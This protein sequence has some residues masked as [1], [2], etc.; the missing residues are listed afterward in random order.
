M[1]MQNK[2]IQKEIKCVK[3]ELLDNINTREASLWIKKS[4][5]QDTKKVNT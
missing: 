3:M 1:K 5:P 4:I 2:K